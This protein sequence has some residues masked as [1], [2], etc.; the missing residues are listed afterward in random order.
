MKALVSKA[1]QLEYACIYDR[2]SQQRGNSMETMEQ[3]VERLELERDQHAGAVRR[4]NSAIESLRQ[5]GGSNGRPRA[6]ISGSGASPATRRTMSPEA[7]RKISLA[8]KKRHAA[9]RK[10]RSSPKAPS[11]TTKKKP[12]WTQTP[13]GRKKFAAIRAKSHAKAA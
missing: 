5:G 10:G 6:A 3:L 2:Q 11:G 8:M 9:A 4:L 13:E 1:F 7:R 12:H